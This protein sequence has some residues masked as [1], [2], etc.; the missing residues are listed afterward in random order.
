MEGFS[1]FL[2]VN[3]PLAPSGFG[4]EG[5]M[6]GRSPRGIL[7]SEMDLFVFFQSIR[8]VD[9]NAV[10]EIDSLKH[11]QGVAKIPPDRE[12]FEIDPVV[13]ADDGGHRSV[14]AEQKRV[15]GQG[16]PLAG[17]LDVKMHFRV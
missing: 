8:G 16:D 10:G 6:R 12:F 17:D 9:D 13:G 5:N 1:N 2:R 4:G 7:W 15:N 14:R 3:S 11:F